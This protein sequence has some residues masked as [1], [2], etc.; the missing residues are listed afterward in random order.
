MSP[1]ANSQMVIETSAAKLHE[2]TLRAIQVQPV[3]RPQRSPKEANALLNH[4]TV[5]FQEVDVVERGPLAQLGVNRINGVA[6]KLMIACNQND[7]NPLFGWPIGKQG[8]GIGTICN[9]ACKYQ[10]ISAGTG[11]MM[12]FGKKSLLD[13]AV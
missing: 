5:V 11:P 2:L 1:G 6:I 10:Y 4:D 13:D 7:R 9:V 8:A 3:I 12:R